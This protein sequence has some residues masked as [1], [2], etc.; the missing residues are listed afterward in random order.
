MS[1]S[2]K[3]VKVKNLPDPGGVVWVIGWLFSL[4]LLKFTFWKSVLA[5]ILWPYYL[6]DFISTLIK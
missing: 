6:G 1:E 5:I 2:T 4:G 3:T